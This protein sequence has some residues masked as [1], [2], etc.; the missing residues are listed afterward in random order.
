MEE[1]KNE[2]MEMDN[3][4]EVIDTDEVETSDGS[5]KLVVAGAVIAGAVAL[6]AIAFKKGKGKLR[7]W[8]IKRLEKAGYQ[9][10]DPDEEEVL[11]VEVSEEESEEK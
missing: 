6:G 8:Q 1:M 7:A 10:I 9:V 11:P 2:V 5:G 3:E 4:V